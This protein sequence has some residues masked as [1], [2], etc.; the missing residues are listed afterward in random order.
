M[1]AGAVV[2]VSASAFFDPNIGDEAGI[3]IMFILAGCAVM[4]CQVS[5]WS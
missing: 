5:H 1:N 4:A 3:G 2:V